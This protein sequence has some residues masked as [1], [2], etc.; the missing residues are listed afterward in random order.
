[1]NG[2]L[3]ILLGDD[4]G[5]YGS[6]NDQDSRLLATFAELPLLEPQTPEQGY[7]MLR[8]GFQLSEQLNL[9]VIV[10]ITRSYSQTASTGQLPNPTY[11][12]VQHPPVRDALRFVPSPSNA[13]SLHAALH[14]RLVAT[15]EL[16]EQSPFNIRAGTGQVAI[17]AAGFMAQKLR[18]VLGETI[19]PQLTVINLG[20]LFPLP[21]KMLRHV[22]AASEQVLVIEETEPFVENQLKVLAQTDGLRTAILGKASGHLP[23]V[24]EVFRWHVQAA[25]QRV[26]PDF[27]PG[28]TFTA[29][30]EASERPYRKVPCEGCDYEALIDGLEA[31][32]AAVGQA[33]FI[34]ADPGCI[35]TVANRLH[36]KFAIGSAV[37][38]AE[39]Y[40]L[41]QSGEKTVAIIGDSG[42]FHSNLTALCSAA[43]NQANILIVVVDNGGAQTTGGQTSPNMGRDS[44]GRLAP[45]LDLLDIARA[46]G[47][48]ASEVVSDSNDLEALSAAASRGL[49][50]LGPSVLLVRMDC[51]R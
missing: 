38:L 5:A 3:V 39:G 41:A 6:Q 40:S 17:V 24:G 8:T 9:A 21:G 46:C 36:A 26:L 25:L 33:P 47:L 37:A 1:M 34:A 2:G 32:A 48:A 22:L 10:R 31:G 29:D 50:Y 45:R 4:P 7:E 28:R 35:V 18:D 20:T 19:A 42:F 27:T 12:P 43:V 14:E 15:A 13:V 49:Q 44:S 23:A 51:A 16:F 11:V 30:G